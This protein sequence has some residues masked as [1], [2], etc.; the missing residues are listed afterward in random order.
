MVP[1]DM[2]L[3]SFRAALSSLNN[4]D[5]EYLTLKDYYDVCNDFF[6]R[7]L[8]L[9]GFF[10]KYYTINN[11]VLQSS[12]SKIVVLFEKLFPLMG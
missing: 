1:W 2:K 10:T 7:G 4:H 3:I 8:E 12:I 6:N 9:S 11:Y 5:E